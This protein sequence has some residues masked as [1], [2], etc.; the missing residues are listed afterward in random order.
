MRLPP[1][2]STR[3]DERSSFPGSRNKGHSHDHSG[4]HR[5]TKGSRYIK[6]L[7][8]LSS[9]DSVGT[10]ITSIS[11]LSLS[12]RTLSDSSSSNNARRSVSFHEHV[13]VCPHD[14]P[15]WTPEEIQAVFYSDQDYQ[16]MKW[17]VCQTYQHLRMEIPEADLTN[18][19][20]RGLERMIQDEETLGTKAQC[21][22]SIEMVLQ[23]QLKLHGQKHASALI[24]N[25]Y[26]AACR[27]SS[28]AALALAKED[29]KLVIMMNGITKKKKCKHSTSETRRAKRWTDRFLPMKSERISI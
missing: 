27:S 26:R 9:T 13:M 3:S 1:P 23:T 14:W 17:E 12:N 15:E 5:R 10:S 21:K 4:V 6:D 20:Y 8:R 22:R 24:A 7:P 2:S 25:Q 19:T 18:F 28:R 16:D 29:R 11:T